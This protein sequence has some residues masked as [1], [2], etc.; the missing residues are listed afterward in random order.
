M[1][2][3]VDASVLVGE[4]LRR[5]GLRLLTNPRLELFTSDVAWSETRHELEKRLAVRMRQ[6]QV[7]QE[8]AKR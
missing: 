7:T 2:P 4:L 3:V 5:R 6:G 8:E 1:K